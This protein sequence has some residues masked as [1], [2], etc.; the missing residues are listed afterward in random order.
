MAA[1]PAVVLHGRSEGTS[2]QLDSPNEMFTVPTRHMN[3]RSSIDIQQTLAAG[4]GLH[5]SASNFSVALRPMFANT[6]KQ[7]AARPE[8]KLIG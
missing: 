7:S 8:E 2:F 5:G 6:R 1:R 4:E 3:F